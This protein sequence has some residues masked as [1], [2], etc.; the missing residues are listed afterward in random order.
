MA[1]GDFKDLIRRT[2]SDKI[3]HAAAFNITKNHKYD[4]YQREFAS[5]VY[6]FDKKN[7]W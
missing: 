4:G 6:I 5:T 1:Y 7:F 3:W 2:V